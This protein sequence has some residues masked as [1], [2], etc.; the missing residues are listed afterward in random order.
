MLLFLIIYNNSSIETESIWVRAGSSTV[1]GS[2]APY[3]GIF[4]IQINGNK[5]EA[6]FV[7]RD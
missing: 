1:G 4:T 7:F 6:G 3:N 2:D 5:S